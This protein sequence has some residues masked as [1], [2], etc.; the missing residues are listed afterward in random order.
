MDVSSPDGNNSSKLYPLLATI[1]PQKELQHRFYSCP[2]ICWFFE[3]QKQRMNR[4]KGN[5]L[6]HVTTHPSSL[7]IHLNI[8]LFFLRWSKA[9]SDLTL[10]KWMA[11][12]LF[13]STTQNA[14]P[15]I[16]LT[17]FLGNWGIPVKNRVRQQLHFFK[18]NS[19]TRDNLYCRMSP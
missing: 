13:Q 18:T 12:L 5:V 16:I 7:L 8:K 2:R 4:E 3:I 1:L 10:Q 11:N 19:I 6:T 9:K 17:P 14:L 15:L